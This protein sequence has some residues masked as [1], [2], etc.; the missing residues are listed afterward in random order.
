MSSVAFTD[1]GRKGGRNGGGRSAIAGEATV[2]GSVRSQSSCNQ[3]VSPA[4]P[5]SARAQ[6]VQAWL[7]KI[8]AGARGGARLAQELYLQGDGVPRE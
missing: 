1:G 5:C 6:G 8:G 4:S 7:C 3:M 2:G